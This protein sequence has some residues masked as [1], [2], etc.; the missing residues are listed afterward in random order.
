MNTAEKK[1]QANPEED[2]TRTRETVLDSGI[3]IKKSYTPQDIAHLS[4]EKDIG[5]S[6]KF[7][8]VR[9][10]YPDMYWKKPWTRRLYAGFGN[11][12]ETNRRFRFLLENGQ[13]GLSTALD[14]PTQMGLDSDDPLAVA[15][16]GR[17]GVAIDTLKDMEEVFE[18][19]DL[20]KVSTSFTINATAAIILAM[21]V[22]VGEKQGVPPEKLRGTV[23]NDILKEY[24]ARGQYVFPPKPS[25]KIGADIIEYCILHIPRFNSISVAGSHM[26]EYGATSVQQVAYTFCDALAY[27]DEVLKRGYDHR[28]VRPEHLFPLLQPAEHV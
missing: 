4:Y 8:Y 15:D 22:A 28:S 11:A 24:M 7:P 14:L 2:Y 27:I 19:I 12:T 17:V 25:I 26:H 18:G 3:R 16:V 5:D 6:G 1:A 10:I 21:Y 23:Q 13:T 20:G 9:G